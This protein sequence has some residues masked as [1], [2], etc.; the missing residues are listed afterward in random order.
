M[1]YQICLESWKK[2]GQNS[3]WQKSEEKRSFSRLLHIVKGIFV[4]P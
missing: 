4:E 2:L 1:E 3:Y